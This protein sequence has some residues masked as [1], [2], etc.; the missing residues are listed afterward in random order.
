MKKTCFIITCVIM[1]GCR[2]NSRIDASIQEYNEKTESN[3]DEQLTNKESFNTVK[4]F[5]NWYKNNYKTVNQLNLV[6]NKDVN[7]DSTKIYSVNFEESEK[8]L[9][10]LKSSGFISDNYINKWRKYFKEHDEY[11]KKNPQNDGPPYGFEYDFVLL[12]QEIEK[13]LESID[14][15]KL[16]NVKESDKNSVVKI[17]ITIRL[18]FSLSKSDGKW[19]IDNIENLDIE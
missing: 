10:K 13:T 15:I 19:L 5:L 16:V 4:D 7:Y 8:Y 3:I 12:T 6:K 1:I 18:C 2:N 9:K 14:K 17:D 11:F